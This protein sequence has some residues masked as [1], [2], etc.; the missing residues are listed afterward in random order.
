MVPDTME[1]AFTR[2]GSG[3][4]MIKIISK[5]FH[6]MV[7][8]Q[9]QSLEYFIM[10]CTCDIIRRYKPEFF[11]IHPGNIDAVHHRN[12]LFNEKVNIAIEETDRWIG[13][14][15]KALE[16]SSVKEETNFFLLSDHGQME[17]S[18]VININDLLADYGLIRYDN[19]GNLTG[20]D[21]YCL[22]CGMSAKVFL[23]N[24][25]DPVL[26]KKPRLF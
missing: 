19:Q 26:F 16:D 3:P 21:A 11:M 14:I 15:M 13:E 8:R 9:H 4:D 2:A 23:K 24:P 25:D 6:N 20:W 7:E 18:R 22:S 17:I 5:Y 10:S 12:E 1:T